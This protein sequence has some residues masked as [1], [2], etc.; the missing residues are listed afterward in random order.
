[1][2]AERSGGLAARGLAGDP[3]ARAVS[4]FLEAVA[5]RQLD[6]AVGTFASD[7]LF[8][9]WDGRGDETSPRALAHGQQEAE[10][11]LSLG[12]PGQLRASVCL[13][14]GPDCFVEGRLFDS[15]SGRVI[16]TFV[17]ALQLDGAGSITRILS[18]HCPPVTT[19]ADGNAD[20]TNASS[21]ALPVL[22]EY[23]DH[24]TAGRFRMA[25][26]CFSE[27]CLYSHPPYGPGMPRVEFRGHRELLAGL[28]ER[29]ARSWR[30]EIVTTIQRGPDCFI[31]GVVPN[32]PGGG[33]F[34]SS[35]SLD[36]HGRIRRYVAFYCS[37]SVPRR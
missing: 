27:D 9:Y 2:G 26:D 3:L 29:G 12:L 6:R 7:V 10:S 1:M 8:A 20:P 22:D 18:Y 21:E 14:D 25:V 36:Q 28:E 15:P 13:P 31:E 23:F 5:S 24:L 33:S 16:G 11:A 37:P 4:T 35:L 32:V 17:A 34:I 19:V 30:H